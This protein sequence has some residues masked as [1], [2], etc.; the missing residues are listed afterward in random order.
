[1]IKD[2]AEYL[3]VK[4]LSDATMKAYLRYYRHFDEGLEFRDLSQP[5]IN[6]FLLAH[7]SNVTRAFLT[8]LFEF[9]EIKH[10]KIPK[11]TGRRGHKKRRSLSPQEIKVLK[12]WLYQNKKIR[13][14]LCFDLS[15]YCALRRAE[16]MKI[17]VE[18]FDL[19]GWAENPTGSCRLLIHGKGKRERYV[20]VLSKA[21][22]R[23][24]DYI[25]D[26]DRDLDQRLFS[27]NKNKW[28]D[29]FK[30]A[31]KNTMDYNF[32]LHDLRRSR[33]THWISKGVDISRVKNRLGHQSIQTTQVYINL[34]EKKEFDKW[35]KE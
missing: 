7:T 19:K 15:Y 29:A 3:A 28:H 30:D 6:Q 11:L 26:Q 18:D 22:Y 16:V 9:L 17:Q 14:L 1:M 10:L 2:F 13:Y 33:A 34:D 21:M 8:N 32:T 24:I 5:Y 25:E 20:P 23:I 4:K 27:F 31:V 35:A 12:N